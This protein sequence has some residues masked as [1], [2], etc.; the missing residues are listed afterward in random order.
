MRSPF[1]FHRAWGKSG[2]WLCMGCAALAFLYTRKNSV[3]FSVD[4]NSGCAQIM[5][6]F[7]Q[8]FTYIVF[9]C[10]FIC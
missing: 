4:N 1:G 8:A 7:S 5:R 3:G 10:F 2:G 6:R 9:C